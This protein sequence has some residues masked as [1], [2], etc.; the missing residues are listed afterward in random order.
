MIDLKD[1]ACVNPK[2]YVYVL[3]EIVE[4]LYLFLAGTDKEEGKRDYFL[5]FVSPFKIYM[6]LTLHFYIR[7]LISHKTA[8]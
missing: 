2:D 8:V 1:E 7:E 6:N 3:I 5:F 4:L